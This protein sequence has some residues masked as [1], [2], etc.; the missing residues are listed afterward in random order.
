[1]GI[2]SKKYKEELKKTGALDELISNIKKY[3]TVTL[4]YAA[5]D[6]Q[7]NHEVVLQGLLQ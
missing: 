3:K 5:R 7:H 2:I 6:E 4:L 1:M